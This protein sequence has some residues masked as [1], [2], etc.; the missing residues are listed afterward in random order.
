M[1]LTGAYF[2]HILSGVD[3]S[4]GSPRGSVLVAVA[5][6]AML[7]YAVPSLDTRTTDEVP[8]FEQADEF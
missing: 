1:L 4:A 3:R 5:S 6:R 2:V 8:T 7:W